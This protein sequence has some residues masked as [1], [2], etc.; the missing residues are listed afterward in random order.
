M[1]KKRVKIYS[2]R[3]QKTYGCIKECIT[4]LLLLLRVGGGEKDEGER[5]FYLYPLWSDNTFEN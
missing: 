5:Y 1:T 3:Q 2:M 4:C